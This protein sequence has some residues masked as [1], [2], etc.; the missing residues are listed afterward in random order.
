MML[1]NF[2]NTSLNDNIKNLVEPFEAQDYKKFKDIA[3]GLKG[4][5]TYIGASRLYYACYA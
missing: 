2:E 4:A 3:H 5:C 1:G